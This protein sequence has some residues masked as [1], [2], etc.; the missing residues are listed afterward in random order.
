MA[1]N[2][3]FCSGREIQP[4][5]PTSVRRLRAPGQ[6]EP[7]PIGRACENSEAFAGNDQF[8]IA[9]PAEIGELYVRRPSLRIDLVADP[10]DLYRASSGFAQAVT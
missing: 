5:L 2:T 9:A 7:V 6:T 8:K 4:R 3:A 1:G 10:C